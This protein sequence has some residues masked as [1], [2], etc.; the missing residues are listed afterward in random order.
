MGIGANSAYQRGVAPGYGGQ[1]RPGRSTGISHKVN[2][3]TQI[4]DLA[5]RE[6]RTDQR[7]TKQT[8]YQMHSSRKKLHGADGTK[9]RGADSKIMSDSQTSNIRQSS[10]VNNLNATTSRE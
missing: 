5:V 9:S 8:V 1:L 3:T 7:S 2:A 4:D 6:S 10:T